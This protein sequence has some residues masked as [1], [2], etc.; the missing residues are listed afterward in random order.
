MNK[1]IIIILL[2]LQKISKLSILLYRPANS[3]VD[4]Q[5]LNET[6]EQVSRF[7]KTIH[8]KLKH[9]CCLHLWLQGIGIYSF[10]QSVGDEVIHVQ[11]L[12]FII[13]A[14]HLSVATVSYIIAVV[15]NLSLSISISAT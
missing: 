11:A 6:N 4:P 2:A 12:L 5:G 13:M 3:E 14:T 7:Y 15:C 1:L 10:L 9:V 8:A